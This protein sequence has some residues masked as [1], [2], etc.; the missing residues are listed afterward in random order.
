M[1]NTPQFVGEAMPTIE[2]AVTT[3]AA[4]ARRIAESAESATATVSAENASHPRTG[5]ILRIKRRKIAA[6]SDD[7]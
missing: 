6:V 2:G 3:R 7:L 1:A 4:A 5:I